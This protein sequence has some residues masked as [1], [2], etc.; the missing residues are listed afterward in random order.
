MSNVM[1]LQS[2]GPHEVARG[3]EP[4]YLLRRIVAL[5]LAIAVAVLLATAM[6]GL[7]AGFGG[8]PAAASG[9]QPAASQLE[10]HVAQRGDTLW[11]IAVE[12]HG[13]V[14]LDRYVDRLID[15]N[16]GTRILVGQAVLLP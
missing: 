11:T 3:Q 9:A 1:V 8:G 6:A 16:S 12:H 10:Y 14:V 4:D 15:L 5:L 7:L 13:E 2:P